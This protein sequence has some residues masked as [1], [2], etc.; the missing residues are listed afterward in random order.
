MT[1]IPSDPFFSSQWYLYNPS[2]LDLNVVNVWDDYTG[3][4]VLVGVI[5]DGFD[6]NHSDLNDN[7]D[8]SIDYDYN[9]NDS[10][11]F[12]T[13]SNSHGTAV[14][15]IIGAEADNGIGGVGIAFKATIT[16]FRAISSSNIIDATT[17][18][19]W[20]SVYLDVV[21]NSWGF[22]PQGPIYNGFFDNFSSSSFSSTG[23]AIVNAVDNGRGGLGT[24][25]VF[26][27][28]NHDAVGE[29]TN[30]H[31]LQNSRFV[32]TVAAVKK[33]GYV[34]S[35]STP[36]AS[37]LVSAFGSE[38]ASIFTTDRTGSAGSTS[39]DYSATFNGTS[40]AAPMVSGVVA[41]MLEANPNLGYRDIQEI[42]AY[43]ARQTGSSSSYVTN[44]AN[45]WNGGGLHVSHDLG[46]GL[47]DALAAVRLAETWQKQSTYNNEASY[48]LSSG[49]LGSS[50][51]IPDF[52]WNGSAANYGVSSTINVPSSSG[53]E[54][55]FVEVE[56]NISHTWRGDLFVRLT[57][58]DGTQSDLITVPGEGLDS[59][60]D[61]VFKVSSSHN[62]GET[63]GGNWT[64][65]V[66]DLVGQTIYDSDFDWYYDHS[67]GYLNS[68]TLRLYG[69]SDTADD[70]YIYTNEFA[71]YT[72]T[73]RQTLNDTSGIDTINA[74]AISSNTYLDLTPGSTASTL[75][76]K[77][78]TIGTSTTIEK[79]F[80][81]D[82]NDT[83]IGNSAANFLSSG[84]GDDLLTGAAGNDTL[85]GGTGIDIVVE[86]GNVNFT[87]TN[88]TLTGNG[89]DSLSNIEG[90]FLIG[91]SGNN[92]LNASGSSLAAI[93][94]DGDA[95][96]DTLKGGS[97][98]DLLDGGDGNDTLTGSAGNDSFTG[99]AGTDRV[100]E[101]GNVNFTLTNTTLTGNGSDTLNSIERATLTGGTG[102]NN[103]NASAF[104]LGAVTLNGEAGNDTLKA[105]SKNDALN[106]GN[107]NDTLT[108]NA[109]NDTLTGGAG[110][111]NLTGGNGLDVFAFGLS[112][113]GIDTIA[114]FL[115]ASDRIRVSASGFGG[116]LTA[117]TITASQFVLGSTA[118]DA[119]DR[120][121]YNQAN[122]ALFFDIDG[123]GTTAQIQLA[124]LS[125]LSSMSASD[126]FAV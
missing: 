6:Y 60:N 48:S 63:S 9:D 58:P 108:G 71:N 10:N 100:S 47:V 65:T 43:S 16:G 123:T 88:T 97:G 17:N 104:T 35:Y 119:L 116:G 11:P 112:N 101:T 24:A 59:G 40:A 126:I 44:G 29:N 118:L 12:G 117:G 56:L 19:L 91:G 75:A 80:G 51:Y 31:N 102:N 62:W 54:I 25:I 103:L 92:N 87:L 1:T 73:S 105:G 45:N 64:L 68:W 77:S 23:A 113:E 124:T 22:S 83:I 3:Q 36:G 30:Y 90:V 69:D 53:L 72:S 27:A 70:T 34:T 13:S 15:G 57:S 125:N 14:A 81:G 114:D 28:G 120:F 4:G 33:D 49:S 20:D 26:A 21:N 50:G 110:S 82:G 46:F 37:I 115:S 121:I 55:D 107:G 32:T 42:L 2:G 61:I 95:G 41:L 99:G 7:Y 66:W 106:G 84:R 8:T 5:D 111:D 67:Y 78:L 98:S 85:D 93:A 94:L 86:S 38:P 76:G 122:G 89:T 96:N 52:Y 39:G 74:A 79:A 109:G 18:A